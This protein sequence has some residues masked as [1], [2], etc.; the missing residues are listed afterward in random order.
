MPEITF[1]RSGPIGIPVLR[2]GIPIG[3]IRDMRGTAVG[4]WL[5]SV[6][7]MEPSGVGTNQNVHRTLNAAQTAINRHFADG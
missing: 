6:S 2:D 5:V 1:G 4:G 7:G 3:A